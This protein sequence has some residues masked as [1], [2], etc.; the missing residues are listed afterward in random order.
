[1]CTPARVPLTQTVVCQS[2]APKCSFTRRPAQSAGT[3]KVRLYQS[4]SF[5]VMRRWMPE[6]ADSATNGTRIRSGNV[7]GCRRHGR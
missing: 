1:M 7:A 3:V 4:L 2:E 6:S 5:S